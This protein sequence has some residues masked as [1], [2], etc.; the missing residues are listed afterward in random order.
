MFCSNCGAQLKNNA[1][2]CGECAQ[3]VTE[4]K[5]MQ[6]GAGNP[7]SITGLW[8]GYVA[9][10]SHFRFSLQ[11]KGGIVLFSYVYLKKG[12]GY[13]EQENVPVDP[14]YMQELREFVTENDYVYLTD[15]DPSKQKVFVAD[16]PQC[17]LTLKWEDYKP[18]LIR[19]RNLP[20]NGEKLK[21]FFMDIA[22]HTQ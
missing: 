3:P 12:C 10:R 18:L 15:H 22:E 13:I 11:E 20:P 6:R 14:A 8:L 4:A 17:S 9:M 7:A 1:R 16:A 19:S 21:E 2:F 5:K